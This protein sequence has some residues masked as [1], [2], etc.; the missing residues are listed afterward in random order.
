MSQGMT[1]PAILLQRIIHQSFRASCPAGCR[2]ARSMPESRSRQI[3]AW[4]PDDIGFGYR[5]IPECDRSCPGF[6]K[7]TDFPGRI[8]NDNRMSISAEIDRDQ[9]MIGNGCRHQSFID[10]GRAATKHLAAAR[11]ESFA[12]ALKL[13]AISG[14]LRGPDPINRAFWG[15]S[16]RLCKDCHC[17]IMGFRESSQ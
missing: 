4:G 5:S 9:S 11:E 12:C 8:V 6:L 3:P 14:D 1:I 10:Q 13:Y 2:A 16:A 7:R 17:V 15:E